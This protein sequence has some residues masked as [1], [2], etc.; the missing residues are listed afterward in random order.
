[1]QIEL[2]ARGLS[3]ESEKAV[4]VPYRGIQIEGQQVDLVV[5]G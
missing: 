4:T 5:K 2:N 1:M 3:Y